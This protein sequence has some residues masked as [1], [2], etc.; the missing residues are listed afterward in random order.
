MTYKDF[1]RLAIKLFAL[2][3]IV[4]SL[5][6]TLP[7]LVGYFSADVTYYMIVFLVVTV[8]LLIGMFYYLIIKVDFIVD[9]FRLDK[10]FD[11]QEIPIQHLNSK[12]ILEFGVVI[13]GLYMLIN[14]IPDFISD[15]FYWVSTRAKGYNAGFPFISET[16]SRTQIGYHFL[17]ILIGYLLVSNFDRVVRFLTPKENAHRLD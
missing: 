10:G 4:S 7:Q 8:L 2:M 12:N 1:F 9:L 6:S 15:A 14:A 13:I 16:E 3:A 11:K 5:F 17:Q